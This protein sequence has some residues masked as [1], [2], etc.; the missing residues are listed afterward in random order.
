MSASQ[1]NLISPEDFINLKKAVKTEL[2]RRSNSNSYGS[3]SAYTTSAQDYTT[4]PASGNGILNEHIKKIT[5]PIDAVSGSS[6]TP[7]DGSY[8]LA[9]SI[10]DAASKLNELS[11]KSTTSSSSGCKSS[12]SGLCYSGCYSGCDGC[13]GGCSGC[14]GNCTGCDGCGSGCANGCSSCTGGC[15]NL[16]DGCGLF[17]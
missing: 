4:T 9:S 3:M 6:L 10:V 2:T 15:S 12:C 13:S 8:I 17:W 1:G 14:D 7:S 11:S 16:C 5:Q